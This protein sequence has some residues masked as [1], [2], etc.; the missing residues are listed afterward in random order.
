MRRAFDGGPRAVHPD[1]QTGIRFDALD[2][3]RGVCALLV[4]L[5]HLPLGWSLG[6]AG[7]V[8]NGFLFVDFFFV[9][10]GFVISHAYGGRIGG[11]HAY[12]V[13]LI[14]RFGRVWPLHVAMLLAFAVIEAVKLAALPDP[15]GGERNSAFAFVT[16]LLLLHGLGI[17]HEL[18]WNPQS[19][20]ISTEF[21]TYA[22]FG[23]LSLLGGTGRRVLILT[24]GVAGLAVV[25]AFSPRGMDATYDFGLF[26]CLYGFAAGCAVYGLWRRGLPFPRGVTAATVLE[27]VAA[28]TAV[29]FVGRAGHTPL[30]LAAPLVFAGVVWVFAHEA[31]AL[32][33]GLRLPPLRRLGAWSYGIYMVHGLILYASVNLMGLAAR[34]GIDGG[35]V[36]GDA[37]ALA[38]TTAV[39]ALAALTARLVEEPGRR[40]F[41]RLAAAR[42]AR[43]GT[44]DAYP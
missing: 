33:R 28:V 40:V 26:R 1:G 42:H 5:Y 18:T 35:T 16:N 43:R 19:W 34:W 14:R 21:W 37:A 36:T 12:G 17:H 38:Y 13:F 11:G 10:S 41:N 44:A 25:A 3:W 30:A 27:A 7:F 8:R 22:L 4:A 15:D 23:L 20:S 2:S 6:D 9:L 24:M 39:I 29:A 32:S 31:G